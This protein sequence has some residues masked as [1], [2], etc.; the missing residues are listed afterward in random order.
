MIQY[1]GDYEQKETETIPGHPAKPIVTHN[2][3]L[4]YAELDL[5]AYFHETR[6]PILEGEV[7]RFWEDMFDVAG[8]VAKIHDL[9]VT[10]G[11]NEH[12]FYG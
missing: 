10:R 2:I 12:K 8:A 3:I 1:L 9:T 11:S 5:D 4:E 6:P 7:A